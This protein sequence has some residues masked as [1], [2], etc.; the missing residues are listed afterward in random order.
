MRMRKTV[1][2]DIDGTISRVGERIKYLQQ[3]LKDWDLF[4][5]DC[6]E[7]EPIL[8]IVDLVYDLYLQRYNIVFC[9]CRRESCREKT[10]KWLNQHFEPEIAKFSTL[11]MRHNNDHRHDIEVKPELL[12]NA[13]IEFDSIAF[14]LEDRNSMVK[15]WREL[16]LTCLQVAEGDF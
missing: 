8:N 5:N 4:Y 2:V 14:I 6:F 7:D 1:I 16:G 13:G 9:T 15:K 12:K 3:E 10:I 11:L